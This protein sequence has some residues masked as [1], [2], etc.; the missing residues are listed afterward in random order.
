MPVAINRRYNVEGKTQTNPQPRRSPRLQEI[1]NQQQVKHI[2]GR[3]IEQLQP[4]STK[5][6]TQSG[7]KRRR[8]TKDETESDCD[9]KRPKH[10]DTT[11]EKDHRKDDLVKSWLGTFCV[12]LEEVNPVITDDIMPVPSPDDTVSTSFT[13]S[14]SKSSDKAS[15]SPYDADYRIA[16]GY[17]DIYI[18]RVKPSTHLMQ[19]AREITTRSRSSPEVNAAI[20]KEVK[21]TTRK[22]E[23]DS[24]E[25]I[26]QQ[27]SPNV[28]PGMKNLPGQLKLSA[29]QPWNHSVP[30][31]LKPSVLIAPLPLARP[32]PDQIIGYAEEA[33]TENQLATVDLLTDPFG[34]KYGVVNKTLYF[35]FIGIEYKSQAKG[36]SHYVALNQAT[37]AGAIA[38]NGFIELIQRGSGLPRLDYN[39]PQFFS[40]SM[41]QGYIQINVHWI[42][43]NEEENRHS[44]HVERLSK[45]F[46][47]DEDGLKAVQ[48]AVKNIFDWVRVERLALICKQLDAYRTKV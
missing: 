5:L 32:K 46:F 28:I 40:L 15:I 10:K 37:G 21:E 20:I 26:I 2:V 17:R 14:K 23:N 43:L 24:E 25:D 19:R 38:S 34:R 45:H 3:D 22:L 8:N 12:E 35:P 30:I 4:S 1:A 44:F 48:R 18:N 7:F 33:F 9:V 27:L 13:S 29:G 42:K 31:P 11:A 41:D 6:K 16:L 47:D 36:G 39:E